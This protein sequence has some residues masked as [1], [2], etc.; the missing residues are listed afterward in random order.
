MLKSDMPILKPLPIKTKGLGFFKKNWTWLTKTREWEVVEDWYYCL[1]SGLEIL[2]PSGFVFD[3][4]S[5]P[6][7]AWN[8]LSP[9]GI[10]FIPGLVHDHGY[11]KGFLYGRHKNKMFTDFKRKDWDNLFLEICNDV[12]GM[13]F[14]SKS[15]KFILSCFGFIAWNNNKKTK[16]KG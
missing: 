16:P 9:T 10:L 12:N 1:P 2:I 11:R 6:R 3:G 4:A 14:L 7:I 13:Y 8:I 15:S 5:V